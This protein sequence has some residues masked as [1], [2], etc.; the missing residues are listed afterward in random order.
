MTDLRLTEQQQNYLLCFTDE[1]PSRTIIDLSQIFACSRPNAKKMLDRMV[2]AGVLYKEKNEYL[3]TEIGML[4]KEK[5]EHEKELLSM[6]LQGIFGLEEARA[7]SLSSQLLGKGENCMACFLSEKS[8][9][10]EQLPEPGEKVPGEFLLQILEKKSYPVHLTIFQRHINEEEAVIRASMANKVFEHKAEL[11]IDAS[12][13]VVFATR[14]LKKEHKGHMKHGAVKE[15]V[16]QK[17]GES[18]AIPFKDQRVEIPLD[19]FGEWTYL[20]GGVLVSY[21]WFRSHAAVNFSGHRA[22]ANYLLVLNLAQC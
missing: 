14:S 17:D 6:T 10:F 3:V 22:E 2:K 21:T 18:H 4:I 15:L 19:V 1:H 20:G 12:P 11:V 5:L 13:H 16:Y 9:L 8:K 7:K